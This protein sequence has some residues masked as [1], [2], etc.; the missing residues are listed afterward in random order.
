[1]KTILPVD[2][3]TYAFDILKDL[4]VTA[5][6]QQPG[7]PHRIDGMTMGIVTM[8]HDAPHGGEVHPNGDEIIYV[9]S[10]RLRVRCDS[11]P[12]QPLELG[13]GGACIIK[14]GE[15]HKIDVLEKTQLIHLTPGPDG[16][17]RP[18]PSENKNQD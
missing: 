16:D 7:P 2:V 13:A 12:D 15:W 10:G 4:S 18:L 5:R 3:S 8:E 9:I 14:K 1:M 17:H 11:E 6:Q